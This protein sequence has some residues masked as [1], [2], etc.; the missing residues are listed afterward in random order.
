MSDRPF[1]SVVIPMYNEAERITATLD[2][3]TDYLKKQTYS[4]EVIVVNDGSTDKS[5]EVVTHGRWPHT[6]L[7]E[8]H[9]NRGKGYAVNKGM[10]EARGEY[11]AMCDA[12]N[13]TPFEQIERLFKAIETCDMA[14]GSRYVKG[15]HIVLKQPWQR[16]VGSRVGNLLVQLMILPGINDTQCGFKLFKRD[17]AKKIAPLQTVW[18]WGFDMELLVIGKQ[19][20][21]KV[22]E[23]PVD[24]YDRTGSK[25]HS[26]RAFT[27]TLEELFKIRR[28]RSKKIYKHT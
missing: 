19:L 3:V 12:D 18:R 15:S 6:A 5:T 13:A 9:R 16:I 17:V 25:V 4:W 26:G 23:V 14:I 7:V 10:H 20:G 1:L 8:Y 28:N 2:Y 22:K 11:I 24:W 27:S 21:Y